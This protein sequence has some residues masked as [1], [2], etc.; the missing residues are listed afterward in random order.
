MAAASVGVVSLV[1]LAA[2]GVGAVS[3]E[4]TTGGVVSAVAFFAIAGTGFLY[5]WRLGAGGILE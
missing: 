1:L 2:Y 5:A 4:P 3:S